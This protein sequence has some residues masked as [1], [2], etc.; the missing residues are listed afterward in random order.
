MA[1]DFVAYRGAAG[2]HDGTVLSVYREAD[3]ARVVVRGGSGSQFEI[4]FSGVASITQHR[5]EGMT[6]YALAE[7]SADPPLRRFVFTAWDN[8]DEARLEVVAR[9]IDCRALPL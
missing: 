5:A 8:E 4:G 9:D 1:D 6:L 3:D 2:L 7:M